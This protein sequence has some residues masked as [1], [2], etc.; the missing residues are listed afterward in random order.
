MKTSLMKL[1]LIVSTGLEMYS[2]GMKRRPPSDF[3][4]GLELSIDKLTL[5]TGGDC[6]AG[7]D[8]MFPEAPDL[9]RHFLCALPD[10]LLWI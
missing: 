9:M 8:V 3:S 7:F 1:S 2:E 5:V 10:T 6:T 4:K